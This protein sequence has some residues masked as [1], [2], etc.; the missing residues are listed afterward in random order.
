MPTLTMLLFEVRNT[1]SSQRRLHHMISC[2]NGPQISANG[3]DSSPLMVPNFW[4]TR[5]LLGWSQSFTSLH[6]VRSAE[7]TSRSTMNLEQGGGI[8]RVRKGRGLGFKVAGAQI[9]RASCRERVLF[10]V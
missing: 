10:E 5:L 4:M 6:I 9:G 1:I 2:V 7:P 3:C 8:W